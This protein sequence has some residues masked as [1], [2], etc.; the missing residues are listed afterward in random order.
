MGYRA[1]LGCVEGLDILALET[2]L[3]D[4]RAL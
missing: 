3:I 1:N 2:G 4:G